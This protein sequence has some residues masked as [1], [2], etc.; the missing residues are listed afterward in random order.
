M[1][2]EPTQA[3]PAETPPAAETAEGFVPDPLAGGAGLTREQQLEADLA[4][5]QDRYMRNLAETENFKK[6][7]ARER[8]EERAYAAQEVVLS[9]L[10]LVDNLERALQAAKG[11][12]GEDADPALLQLEKGV[13]LVLKQFEDALKKQGVTVIDA[14]IGQPFDPHVHQALLQEPSAEHPE[15]AVLEVLQKGF[16]MGDRLVRPS[17]VKVASA[18]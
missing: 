14:V 6:R 9:L 17:L 4:E 5:A 7:V 1:S 10:P 8:V 12:A 15:G 2:E 16:K 3:Q 13:E 18:A 11:Q